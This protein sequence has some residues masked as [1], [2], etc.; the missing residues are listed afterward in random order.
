MI[1]KLDALFNV[2]II[3]DRWLM[4]DLHLNVHRQMIR[5]I[6]FFVRFENVK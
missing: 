4:F 5:D 1:E 3:V 6:R 2:F